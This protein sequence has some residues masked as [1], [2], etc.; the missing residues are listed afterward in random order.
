M[1]R[2]SFL[3]ISFLFLNSALFANCGEAYSTATYALSHTKKSLDSN[4]FDHQMYYADR[5]I[6]ALEKTK[7]LAENCGCDNSM[8]YILNGLVDLK[9]SADPE[10]W[11]KGRYFAQKAY[12][13]LQ[14]L[15]SA[16]DICTSSAPSVN[17][18]LEN[19]TASDASSKAIQLEGNG[20][21]EKQLQLERQ[22]QE[23]VEQQRVLAEKIAE[24]KR[25]TA[26]MQRARELEY[27]EQLKLKRIA[28]LTFKEYGS[29]LN[30]L[31][32]IFDCSA[33]STTANWSAERSEEVLRSETLEVTK[34]YYMDKVVTMQKQ[35]LDDFNNCVKK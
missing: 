9:K 11:D 20:L 19:I 22:Q 33:S 18:D 3:L 21:K 13:E 32:N 6:N 4:N 30:D 27:E 15:I 34:K 28:E 12:E 17:Y 24:Q 2:L 35:A 8:D 16:F 23:L 31:M 14:S 1:N 7:G 29:K 5:A 10:D 26:Q 25:L